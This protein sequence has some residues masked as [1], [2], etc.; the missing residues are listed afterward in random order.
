MSIALNALLARTT[1]AEE[2]VVTPEGLLETLADPHLAAK[3]AEDGEGVRFDELHRTVLGAVEAYGLE[4]AEVDVFEP[5][6]SSP[7]TLAR[8]QAIL[9]ADHGDQDQVL[10][11]YY[12]QGVLIGDWD[13]P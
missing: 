11:A 7:A 3:N 5:A 6:D 10:L 2:P 8:L 9:A 1:G 4:G 12:N 13:G